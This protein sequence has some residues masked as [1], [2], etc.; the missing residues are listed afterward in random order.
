MSDYNEVFRKARLYFSKLN[1]P[2]NRLN[3]TTSNVLNKKYTI[4]D[5]YTNKKVHFGDSRYEDYTYHHDEVR[6]TN[7]LQR[8]KKIKGSWRLNPFSPN[9]LSINLLW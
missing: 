1:I 8:A 4:I 9:N 6:R 5:P 3:L 2:L 7:Y